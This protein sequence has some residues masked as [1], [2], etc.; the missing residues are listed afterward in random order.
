MLPL[1]RGVF[2][3]L[4]AKVICV[5]SNQAHVAERERARKRGR[6]A[7][8]SEFNYD[9]ISSSS[10]NAFLLQLRV[11]EWPEEEGEASGVCITYHVG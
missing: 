10:L 8:R 9:I 6:N 5:F 7:A 11:E 4:L 3:S 1:S 2:V